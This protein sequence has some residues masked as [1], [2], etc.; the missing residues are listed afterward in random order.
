MLI[1]VWGYYM[2]ENMTLSKVFTIQMHNWIM[3]NWSERKR[4]TH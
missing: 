3:E 2:H 4:L 1:S